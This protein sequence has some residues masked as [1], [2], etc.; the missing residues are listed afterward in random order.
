MV[1]RI[2]SFPYL[3]PGPDVVSAGVWMTADNVPAFEG[4]MIREWD[5]YYLVEARRTVAVDV[6][7]LREQCRLSEGARVRISSAWYSPGTSLR[8][9]G[10]DGTSS[11]MLA[12]ERPADPVVLNV[13]I[14]GDQLAGELR[15]GTALTLVSPGSGA[16]P[17]S[18]S[19]PGSTL[20]SDEI[21]IKV[22]GE[23]ARFPIQISDFPRENDGAAWY[24]EIDDDF[25]QPLM[26]S[27]RV[28]LNSKHPTI[29]RLTEGTAD[30]IES[31][32][33]LN[34]L[35]FDT[36]RQLL[37]VGLADDT[38]VE[39]SDRSPRDPPYDEETLGR[40][41]WYLA[42]TI[43]P[44]RTAGELRNLMNSSAPDFERL[45]QHSLKFLADTPGGP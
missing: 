9:D 41:V 7:L 8:S 42:R 2:V 40:A 25:S 21:R 38:F 22:E 31:E 16:E 11:H 12:L 28:C 13:R 44:E 17:V 24:L 10:E 5:P 33:I 20:W 29:R 3:L 6:E 43:A 45:M 14:P 15:I 27:V 18:P 35:Y 34:L 37:R 26:G 23:A 1:S 39:L 32:W 19:I 4:G 36:G 30:A